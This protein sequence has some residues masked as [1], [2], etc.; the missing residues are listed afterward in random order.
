MAFCH[1]ELGQ[2]ARAL[3][4]YGQAIHHYQASYSLREAFGDTGGMAVALIHLGSTALLQGSLEASEEYFR[5]SLAIYRDVN[6]QGGLVAALDGLGQTCCAH[7]QVHTA[8]QHLSAALQIAAAAPFIALRLSLLTNIGRLFLRT[9]YQ[10]RGID[11][12]LFVRHHAAAP[13]HARDRVEHLLEPHRARI[14][15]YRAS[16]GREHD[17]DVLTTRIRNDLAALVTQH[18]V[19]AL[20]D[21]PRRPAAQPPIELLTERERELLVLLAHGH[22]YEEIAAHLIIA[23]GTV[24]SHAHNIYGKLGVRNRVQAAARAAELGLL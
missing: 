11:V 7:G 17:L 6:D 22:S 8:A 19:G 9:R 23:V 16:P 13:D 14:S 24:K 10:E 20:T 3:G 15:I 18:D 2:A 4:D 1:N 5:R 21:R 12:L